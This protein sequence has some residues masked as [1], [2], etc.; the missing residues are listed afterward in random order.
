MTMTTPEQTS[1]A[2]TT[3]HVVLSYAAP[4]GMMG[5]FNATFEVAPGGTRQDLYMKARV[6]LAK[7]H[8]GGVDRAFAVTGFSVGRNEL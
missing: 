2:T 4:G 5:D 1:Q 3:Y 6:D 8:F 7:Q